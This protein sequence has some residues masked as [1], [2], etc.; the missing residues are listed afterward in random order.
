MND[1]FLYTKLGNYTP[2]CMPQNHLCTANLRSALRNDGRLA[3]QTRSQA[4]RKGEG[5]ETV[6]PSSYESSA[7]LTHWSRDERGLGAVI[8]QIRPMVSAALRRIG[9]PRQNAKCQGQGA[10][11]ELRTRDGEEAEVRKHSLRTISS[12]ILQI[13]SP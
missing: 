11:L 6:L 13:V 3:R 8:S 10:N 1:D 12:V 2:R 9:L 7:L 5:E 4:R